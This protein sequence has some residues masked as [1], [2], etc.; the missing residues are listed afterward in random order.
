MKRLLSKLY[1]SSPKELLLYVGRR[2]SSINPLAV[3]DRKNSE[4]S[5]VLQRKFEVYKTSNLKGINIEE[6]TK[7]IQ[8]R[9]GA[10]DAQ[11]EGYSE[12]EIEKQRDLS[13]KFH[14]GHNHDFGDFKMKGR[15]GNRHIDLLANF[16]NFFPVSIDDFKGKYVFDIGCWT[17]GTTLLLATLAKKN[18]CY[19]RSQKVCRDCVIF[20][21]VFWY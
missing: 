20:I 4:I 21:K 7:S 2:M 16:I 8:S 14:W 17:G 1:N 3:D 15:M 11:V 12:D 5:E 6:F 10:I 18:I 19:R 13:I 9:V